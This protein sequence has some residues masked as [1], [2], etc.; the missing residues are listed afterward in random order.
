MNVS[1]LVVLSIPMKLHRSKQFALTTAVFAVVS[2]IYCGTASA[3]LFPYANDFSSAGLPNASAGWSHDAANGEFDLDSSGTS[4]AAHTSSVDITNMGTN[5]FVMSTRFTI[6]DLV[7][8]TGGSAGGSVGFA[9]FAPSGDFTGGAYYLC[10]WTTRYD[11][12]NTTVRILELGGDGNTTATN[13]STDTYPILSGDTFEMRLTGVYNGGDLDLTLE[14]LNENGSLLGM[15]TATDT[16]PLTGQYFGY[17]D[18]RPGTS[19]GTVLDVD[20]DY[21]NIQGVP[22]PSSSVLLIGGI[23]AC[24][25]KRRRSPAS[26]SQT[27]QP[28]ERAPTRL[29]CEDK[30]RR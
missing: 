20:Y 15:A 28:F 7:N 29:A 14:V 13:G 16:T 25:G 18:R 8:P 4:T 12:N 19:S 5:D 23:L 1:S 9:A 26:Q 6:D 22:E 11:V 10:D 30:L 27:E 3:A 24:F 21:L 2:W 17:R